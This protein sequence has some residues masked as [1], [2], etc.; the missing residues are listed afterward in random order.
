MDIGRLIQQILGGVARDLV[1]HLVRRGVD[2][3][4]GPAKHRRDMTADEREKDRSARQTAQRI[5]QV[6]KIARRFWR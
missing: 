3:A 6:T 1:K 5:N 2:R 4:A